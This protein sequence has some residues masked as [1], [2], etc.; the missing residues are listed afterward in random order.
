MKTKRQRSLLLISI[1]LLFGF[2]GLYSI[3]PTAGS[4]ESP[5]QE[6]LLKQYPGEWFYNQRAYPNNFISRE[7]MA[8]AETQVQSILAE[9]DIS[10]GAWTLAGPLNT[11]GRIT[12]VA[13]SPDSD[14]VLY[15]GIATGGIF[16]TTDGGTNWTPI[17]DDMSKYSIGDLAIAPSNAEIIYAGTGEANASANSG[18]FFG[19]GVYRSNNARDPN[20]AVYQP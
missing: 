3:F 4:E 10:G 14:D 18:A 5:T 20:F 12:D 16:K 1:G 6:A 15:V 11:G 19:D 8:K 13:I 9:R 17:F 2:Y 7:A